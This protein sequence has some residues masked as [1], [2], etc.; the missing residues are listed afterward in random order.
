M[1]RMTWLRDLERLTR[2]VDEETAAA[3]RTRWEGL[4]A[5]A[6]SAEYRMK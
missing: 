2:P 6:R 5:H 3:L 1:G 4:P